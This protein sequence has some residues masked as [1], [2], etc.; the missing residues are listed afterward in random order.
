M[1]EIISVTGAPLTTNSRIREGGYVSL[2]TAGAKSV[3]LTNLDK[4]VVKLSSSDMNEMNLLALFGADWCEAN[5]T[6]IDEKRGKLYF[7]YRRLATEIIGKGQAIG[8]YMDAYERNTGVWLMKDG[9]LVVNSRELWRPDGTVLEHGVHEERVYPACGDIGFD[10]TTPEATDAEVQRVLKAFGSLEWAQCSAD[11]M[12]LGWLGVAIVSSALRRRPHVLVTGPAGCGKS[13]IL[14]QMKWLLGPLAYACTSPSTVAGYSQGLGSTSRAVIVDEFEA[15]PRKPR[16]L[17]TF[18]VA[19]SSHSLQE[20][21]NGIVRGSSGGVAKSYRLIS[22]FIAAGISPGKMEPADLTR[23][24]ILESKG[25]KPDAVQLSEFDAREIGPKLARRFVSRWSVYKA[26]EGV[27][28]KSILAAGGDGRM[29][30]TVGTLLAAYF[31]FISDRPATA[32]EA[33]ELVGKVDMKSRIEVHSVSDE[34]RCLEALFSKVLP[35][36]YV[37]GV[38]EVTRSLSI[39]EAILK[40]CENPTDSAQLVTR[41]AQLGLRVALSKGSWRLYVVNSPEHQELRRLFAGTKWA[42]GGWSTVLRRLPGGEES[43]QRMG[44]GFGAA[45]VTIFDLPED[46]A[47]AN[48]GEMLMRA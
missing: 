5:F 31:T 28:R 23:W 19:R 32:D 48:E 43:T 42:F 41:L 27:V 33:K 18:E 26:T 21:D 30:D 13:T 4:R 35:F 38:A 40:V 20:G 37:E 16:C 34:K 45:K 8:P 22:P 36:K 9:E 14:E 46:L 12:L 17:D 1:T 15:D 11:A 24:V 39:G 7:N 47:P 29:A 3:V 2:G 25:R 10:L 44:P 6:D